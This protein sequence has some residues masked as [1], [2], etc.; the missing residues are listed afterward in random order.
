[1]WSRLSSLLVSTWGDRL[2]SLSRN[3]LKSAMN[4]CLLLT[5]EL[6]LRNSFS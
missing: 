2:E 1:M 5:K 3:S 4:G 6:R